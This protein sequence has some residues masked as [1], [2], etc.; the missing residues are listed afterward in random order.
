MFSKRYYI[1]IEFIY[2]KQLPNRQLTNLKG[3]TLCLLN[4]ND[5]NIL[6]IGNKNQFFN[7]ALF[8]RTKKEAH[9][10]VK[11]IMKQLSSQSTMDNYARQYDLTYL[12][13]KYNGFTVI[14]YNMLIKKI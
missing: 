2:G 8:I 11:H 7:E 12:R 3:E 4:I 6:R 9:N 5:S 13:N 1:E 14:N 10:L